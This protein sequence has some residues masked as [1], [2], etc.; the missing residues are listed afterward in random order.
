VHTLG[1]G[2]FGPA[3]TA[4]S[5]S[6]ADP[7]EQTGVL[8]LFLPLPDGSGPDDLASPWYELWR[9]DI[10]AERTGNLMRDVLPREDVYVAVADSQKLDVSLL[11]PTPDPIV[12][13]EV[14]VYDPLGVTLADPTYADAA[15]GSLV[16]L[17]GYPNATRELAGSVGR[18]L[19]DEEALAAIAELGSAGDPEGA[20]AY[21]PEVEFMIEGAA[22]AGMSGG[23]VVDDRGRLVGVLVRA[24]DE[25]DGLQYVRAVRLSHVVDR[26][27]EALSA[28]DPE[29]REAVAGY[30]EP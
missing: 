18:V 21:D 7:G 4:V 1:E 26:L 23:P 20:V 15:P 25:R 24:S 17:L 22:A 3:G 16:L 8:R 14:A 13:G 9:P 6:L 10:A 19:S 29:L 5:A 27:A 28:A 11:S 30:L 12:F 2:W